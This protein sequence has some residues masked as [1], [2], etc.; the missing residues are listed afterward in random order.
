MTEV[1]LECKRCGHRFLAKVFEPGEV[2]QKQI[3]HYPVRCER[4]KGE[5]RRV[6]V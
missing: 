6:K 4:C 3:P 2:E 1:L 5:V